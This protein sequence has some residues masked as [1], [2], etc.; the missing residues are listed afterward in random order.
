MDEVDVDTGYIA[1]PSS[2]YLHAV[3]RRP[4]TADADDGTVPP[5]RTRGV[6]GHALRVGGGLH[7]F[8]DVDV[9]GLKTECF[10]DRNK[11]HM[12]KY[13]QSASTCYMR[14]SVFS[15]EESHHIERYVIE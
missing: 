8:V 4:P 2:Y 14:A 10:G 1:N 5:A 11:C 12:G 15:R 9:T 13:R 6:D 7:A 3:L